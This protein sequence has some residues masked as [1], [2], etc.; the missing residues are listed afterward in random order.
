MLFQPG[1]L[2]LP[3]RTRHTNN[4][5]VAGCSA[6][7]IFT[8]VPRSQLRPVTGARSI[9][10]AKRGELQPFCTAACSESITLFTVAEGGTT[11]VSAEALPV[12]ILGVTSTV[13]ILSITC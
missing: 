4:T 12:R 6:V 3:A 2:H 1:F 8:L 13:R 11:A 10:E 7:K 9:P 5:R